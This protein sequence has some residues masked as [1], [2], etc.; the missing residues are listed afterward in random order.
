[1]SDIESPYNDWC[2]RVAEKVGRAIC[3]HVDPPHAYGD[4]KLPTPVYIDNAT[5]NEV[6]EDWWPDVH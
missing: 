2:I 6:S 3:D 1:M 4:C 5:G